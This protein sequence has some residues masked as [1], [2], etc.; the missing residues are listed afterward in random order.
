MQPTFAR[1]KDTSKIQYPIKSEVLL[2]GDQ[3]HPLHATYLHFYSAV[4]SEATAR[5]THNLSPVKVHLLEQ[6]RASYQAA[7]S[8]LPQ[9]DCG[10]EHH[11]QFAADTRSSCSTLSDEGSDSCTDRGLSQPEHP[12]PDTSSPS[13]IPSCGFPQPGTKLRP[14]IL[15]VRTISSF[16]DELAESGDDDQSVSPCICPHTPPQ[17]RCASTIHSESRPTSITFSVSVDSWLQARSYERYNN[18]LAAFAEVIANHISAV[19]ILIQKTQGVQ[20]ARYFTKRLASYGEDE[21]S[22]AANLRFRIARLKAN[23]WKME[24]FAPSKY[25]EL[26]A[27]ALAEL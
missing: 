21:E 25:Q 5:L 3:P 20:S 27:R 8:S 16:R 1:G 9:A 12:D 14:S 13:S 15:R 19:D 2:K 6:A 4:S 11:D 17:Q 26:C 23:G 7:A 18:R 22:R 24:R 10:P